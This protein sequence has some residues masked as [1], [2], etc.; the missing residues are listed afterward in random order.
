VCILAACGLAAPVAA[1]GPAE[2]AAERCRA[3]DVDGAARALSELLASVEASQ[4]VGGPASQ[5]VRLNLAH[6]E[7][8]RG[9]A[10][11][12]AE[13]ERMPDP[14]PGAGEPDAALAK[15]LRGL[16]ACA[17]LSQPAE[18]QP[19]PGVAEIRSQDHLDL[20]RGLLARGLRRALESAQAAQKTLRQPPAAERMRLY[21]T[22]ALIQ[23]SSATPRGARG[24]AGRRSD[25]EAERR[26]PGRIT[27]ARL[28]AQ[29]GDWRPPRR[30]SR[31]RRSARSPEERGELDE[32]RGD[33][34]LRLG[35]PRQ[36]L[37]H[38]GRAQQHAAVFG[39][40]DPRR[41]PC[42]CCAARPTARRAIPG[43]E[44]GLSR[45]ASDPRGAARPNIPR[46][47]GR[48]M[49]W[50]CR[51]ISAIGGRRRELRRGAREPGRNARARASRRR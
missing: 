48:A 12:A 43:G 33:L 26:D 7:R 10:A 19:T 32:A 23:L 39:A 13:L 36:A 41:P 42:T 15:A 34:A 27:L 40:S 44:R 22:L 38:L 1:A 24:G 14:A 5:V 31:D 11:R 20:A 49:R 6:V 50:A 17:A 2:V 18:A 29:A 28:V 30:R 8:A 35:S 25:R 21:E 16:R 37:A 46:P 51:R 45:S 9:N 47:R 4:G 3:G